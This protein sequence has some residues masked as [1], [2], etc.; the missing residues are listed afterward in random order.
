VF[1]VASANSIENL[2]PEL[3]R[4]GRFDQIFATGLPDAEERKDILQIHL[5]KRGWGD[6]FSD[7]KLTT[8]VNRMKGFV[9]AEIESTV[10]DAL[11]NSFAEGKD[12]NAKYLTE[13]SKAVV[14]LSVSYADQIQKMTLWAKTHAVPAGKVEEAAPVSGRKRSRRPQIRVKNGET[15]Q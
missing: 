13:A 4:R 2:P 7:D 5:N 1:T 6:V 12:L 3:L 8:I 10:K 15:L 9:G 11:V 14:P